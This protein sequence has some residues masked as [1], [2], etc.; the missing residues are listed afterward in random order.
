MLAVAKPI[1]R[2]WLPDPAVVG[3][4]GM[5]GTAAGPAG[6]SRS[7]ASSSY[8]SARRLA[9][10]G[11]P[12][13]STTDARSTSGSNDARRSRARTTAAAR[14]GASPTGTTALSLKF[15][16]SH[17]SPSTAS[18]HPPA[19][20]AA[21]PNVSRR[22]GWTSRLARAIARAT[23]ARRAGPSKVTEPAIPSSPARRRQPASISS[24]GE[25]PMSRRVAPGRT[26]RMSRNA[27][28]RTSMA[29]TGV[30]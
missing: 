22:L 26:A 4:A 12:K 1:T 24:L 28:S 20:T 14:A 5:A 21:T 6:G 27:L 10:A 3:T 9:T 16:R 8:R 29:L 15:S 13:R 17:S 11:A 25:A 23:S 18:P 2:I 7:R 19:S 30:R